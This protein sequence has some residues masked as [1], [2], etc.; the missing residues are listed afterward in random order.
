MFGYQEIIKDIE[1][2]TKISSLRSN[3]GLL[4]EYEFDSGFYC[5]LLYQV[6]YR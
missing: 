3:G 1:T 6:R 4:V 2:E 5:R